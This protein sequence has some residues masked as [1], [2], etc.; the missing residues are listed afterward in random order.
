M[1]AQIFR[2]SQNLQ[3]LPED[4][5]E[6]IIQSLDLGDI[7]NLRICSKKLAAKSSGPSFQKFLKSRYVVLGSTELKRFM[8]SMQAS[9]LQSFI[10]NLYLDGIASEEA[11]EQRTQD[12]PREDIRRAD[13]A[14]L[15]SQIFGELSRSIPGGV[16]PSLILR[17]VIV[18]GDERNLPVDA[19]SSH[20]PLSKAVWRCN[21]DTFDVALRALAISNLKIKSLNIFHDPDM[22]RY[23]LSCEQLSRTNWNDPGLASSL[24]SLTNLS[25]NIST[26]VIES[27]FGVSQDIGATRI[28][29]SRSRTRP[30]PEREG[31]FAGL[32][33][34]LPLCCRLEEFD[35]IF[36]AL[37]H[38]PSYYYRRFRAEKIFERLVQL[39]QLP[40]LKRLRLDGVIVR[41]TD[42][43][44]FII[45]SQ[46]SELF[47]ENIH[48]QPGAFRSIFEYC[49]RDMA[50][51]SRLH[52]HGLYEMED[53]YGS[54]V[55][56]VPHAPSELEFADTSEELEREGGSV[57]NPITYRIFRQIVSNRPSGSTRSWV[58][59]TSVL[60]A[61]G[62]GEER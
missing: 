21:N 13:E 28:N 14:T 20:A 12:D 5:I 57:R 55:R 54:L 25:I 56:F 52:F 9:G 18:R 41:D 50:A 17:V 60:T 4:I 3:N 23:S 40:S 6:Q 10:Q 61:G 37:E 15:L 59:V 1:L 24:A 51:I 29:P 43:L 47:L 44:D 11:N 16:L 39:D 38:K 34:L 42:L 45:R 32:A 26:P 22:R 58:G 30:Q 35:M 49:T 36:L 48:L 27:D 8:R 46:P 62:N 31:D 19:S 53:V 7:R 33:N 2:M